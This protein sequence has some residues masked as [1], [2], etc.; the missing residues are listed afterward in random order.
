[1]RLM[2]ADPQ[3][4]AAGTPASTHSTVAAEAAS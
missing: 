2:T 1:M 4:M 3:L